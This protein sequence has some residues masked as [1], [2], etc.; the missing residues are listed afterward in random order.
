MVKLVKTCRIENCNHAARLAMAANSDISGI[1]H[2]SL[3]PCAAR[4]ICGTKGAS[5]R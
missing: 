4:A 1:D 2:H 3:K 5:D